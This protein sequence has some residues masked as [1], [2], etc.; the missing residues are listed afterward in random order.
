MGVEQL[1]V[2]TSFSDGI[3]HLEIHRPDAGNAVNLALAEQLLVAVRVAREACETA[4]ARVLL[5]T[6]AGRNFMAGG[7]LAA[8]RADP[9][10]AVALVNTFND[11]IA[12]LADWP[13]PVVCAVQGLAA[14]GGLG[15][16]LTADLLIAEE[17][18]R[19]T[20]GSPAVGLSLDAGTTWSLTRCV[21]PRKATEMS[22]LCT[23][24]DAQA[25]LACGLINEIV[26]KGALL[27]VAT[28]RATQLAGSAQLALARTR[29]LIRQALQNDLKTQ[30]SEEAAAF[31]LCLKSPDFSEGV[32]AMQEKRK[33]R[34]S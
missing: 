29:R 17:G 13:V 32:A 19:F 27:E 24:L 20:V 5:I 2:N 11:V 26:P 34:F 33:P 8:L 31:A 28:A 18:A 23:M 16:A 10:A 1:L 14:G 4:G 21:G 25:A 3:M 22:L 30:L 6:A 7:D 12:L 15:L 9:H